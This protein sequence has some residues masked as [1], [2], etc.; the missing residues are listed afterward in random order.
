MGEKKSGK[1]DASSQSTGSQST[2]RPRLTLIKGM[3]DLK[4]DNASPCTANKLDLAPSIIENKTF[5]PL[6]TT[7]DSSYP[8]EILQSCGSRGHSSP[9]PPMSLW[10]DPSEKFF[11]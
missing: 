2:K 1:L 6:K 10:L 3:A 5:L 11:V 8:D 7:M 4:S 9:P